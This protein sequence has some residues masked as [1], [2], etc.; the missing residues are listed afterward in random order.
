MSA[1]LQVFIK[2]SE[3]EHLILGLRVFCFSVYKGSLEK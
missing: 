2:H 1:I 3:D